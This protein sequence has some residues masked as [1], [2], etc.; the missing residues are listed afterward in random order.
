MSKLEGV[1]WDMD[2]VLVDT[3]K[4]HYQAWNDILPEYGISFSWHTFQTTFGMNNTGLM[5]KLLGHPVDV[6][7]V[8]K[9]SEKKESHFREIIKGQITLIPGIR[10]WL[11]LFSLKGLV[12]A[13]ASSA[14]QENIDLLLQ[15]LSISNYFQAIVS[16]EKIP[17]KPNPAVFIEAARRIHIPPQNCLVV[18]DS[19]AGV[20]AAKKAGMKCIAVT[21]SNSPDDLR[22]ADIIVENL[23]QLPEY[24]LE[25]LF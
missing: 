15:E 12:Q 7:F 4:F 16:G 25:N 8:N 2:G 19:I 23:D 6:E 18:E 24:G 11:D 9:I 13:L 21:T 1:I 10:E 20:N 14:P 22:E 17:G 3:G 5:E